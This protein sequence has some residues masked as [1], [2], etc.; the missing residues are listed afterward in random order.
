M[1]S[2]GN[3]F[4]TYSR[5]SSLGDRDGLLSDPWQPIGRILSFIDGT[6]HRQDKLIANMP[7]DSSTSHSQNLLVLMVANSLDGDYTN[8]TTVQQFGAY[9]PQL[10]IPTLN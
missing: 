5:C 7:E 1:R 10:S 8:T 4:V 2:G 6:T 9:A 3:S